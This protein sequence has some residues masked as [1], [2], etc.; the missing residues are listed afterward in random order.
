MSEFTTV[1]TRDD[2]RKKYEEA[3]QAKEEQERDFVERAVDDIQYGVLQANERGETNY[4]R[5]FMCHECKKREVIE[6]I[7]DRVANIFVDS[8]VTLQ[9][10]KS[11]A[12]LTSS[13][14]IIVVQWDHDA[15]SAGNT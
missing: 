9:E 10:H 4:K 1:I 11:M 3:L 6:E 7:R 5:M 12:Y 14:L 8:V 15:S 2:L 13:Y